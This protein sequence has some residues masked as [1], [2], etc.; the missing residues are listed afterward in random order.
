MYLNMYANPVKNWM[1]GQM[2]SRG[3]SHKPEI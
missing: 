1:E 3:R 2:R